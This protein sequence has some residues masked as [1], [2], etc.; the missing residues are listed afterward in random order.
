MHLYYSSRLGGGKV[1]LAARK[2][3]ARENPVVAGRKAS[4][5]KQS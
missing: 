4:R 2:L 5:N 1:R 3:G